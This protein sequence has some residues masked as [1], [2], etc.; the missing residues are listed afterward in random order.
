MQFHGSITP[1]QFSWCLPAILF[2]LS[3]HDVAHCLEAFCCVQL[4]RA[5]CHMLDWLELDS[6]HVPMNSTHLLPSCIGEINKK[7]VCL[8]HT[9][10]MSGYLYD[11]A[12]FV[13]SD[14][15]H[16]SYSHQLIGHYLKFTN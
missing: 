16:W 10:S 14:I 6:I 12:F 2:N 13:I 4:V 5:Y 15:F 3:A 7:V 9:T 8:Q 11:N 1:V